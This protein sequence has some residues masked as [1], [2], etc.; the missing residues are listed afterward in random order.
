MHAYD[1]SLPAEPL[2]GAFSAL[3]DVESC[4][5]LLKGMFKM[6]ASSLGDLRLRNIACSS[7]EL[8]AAVR[9]RDDKE[10][11]SRV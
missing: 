10:V 9:K 8:H 4:S 11:L 6:S 2:L 3:R 1:T 7:R 5:A